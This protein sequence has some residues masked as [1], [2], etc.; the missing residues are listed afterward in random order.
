VNNSSQN[1]YGHVPNIGKKS[2]DVEQF[3]LTQQRLGLQ[4]LEK[5]TRSCNFRTENMSSQKV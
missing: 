4:K 3:S 5:G 1:S 2:I